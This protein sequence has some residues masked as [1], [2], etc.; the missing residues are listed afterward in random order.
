VLMLTSNM[1]SL[2]QNLLMQAQTGFINLERRHVTAQRTSNAGLD[3][4]IM[5]THCDNQLVSQCLE[6]RQHG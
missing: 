5:Q 6:A 4:F 1:F 3:M 2:S